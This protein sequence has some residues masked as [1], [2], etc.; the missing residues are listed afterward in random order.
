[1]EMKI[2]EIANRLLDLINSGVITED[3][4]NEIKLE[5]DTKWYRQMLVENL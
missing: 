4:L 2:L 3:D 1:M 5:L